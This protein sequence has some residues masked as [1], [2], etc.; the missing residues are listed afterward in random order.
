MCNILAFITSLTFKVKLIFVVVFLDFNLR[1]FFS[2]T[3]QFQ[4]FHM[5]DIIYA[6]PF[7]IN[8]I[9]LKNNRRKLLSNYSE[10]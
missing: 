9:G 1:F 2:K 5:L 10:I 6:R 4:K 7:D 3:E 8:T